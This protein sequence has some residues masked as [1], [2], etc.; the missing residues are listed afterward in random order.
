MMV[1]MM[2]HLGS[3]RYRFHLLHPKFW[4]RY[5]TDS[6]R[7]QLG[8]SQKKTVTE[9][10]R[11]KDDLATFKA[12]ETRFILG[13]PT[14]R[15]AQANAKEARKVLATML[16]N[17]TWPG[18]DYHSDEDRVAWPAVDHLQKCKTMAIAFGEPLSPLYRSLPP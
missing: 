16:P 11:D 5:R 9:E 2:V 1:M 7:F 13:T 17:H 15:A 12:R 8:N 4:V 10:P 6:F 18:I 3:L 14:P